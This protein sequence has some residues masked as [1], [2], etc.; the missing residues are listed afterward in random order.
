MP[1]EGREAL[2]LFHQLAL[3]NYR[4][5]R[6]ALAMA[7]WQGFSPQLQTSGDLLKK[8]HHDYGRMRKDPHDA[9]AAMDFFIAAEH[10]ID[11]HW[12]DHPEPR[13]AERSQEPT[14]TVSHLASGAKHFRAEGPRHTSVDDVRV[15]RGAFQAGA[16][17]A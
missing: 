16:F 12:P 9:Y 11:W 3:R 13:K 6:P 8:L 5:Q 15:R 10:L 2:A 7:K 14:A 4:K 1:V 17:D